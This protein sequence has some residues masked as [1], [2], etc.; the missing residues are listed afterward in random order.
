MKNDN[1]ITFLALIVLGVGAVVGVGKLLQSD[2]KLTFR[3]I[4]G[5]AI[6]TGVLAL[7]A[8]SILAWIPDAPTALIVGIAAVLA[9]VSEQALENLIN[10]YTKGRE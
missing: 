10:K 9:S 8:F 3:L 1:E 2:A 5:R 6:T 7:S 4:I